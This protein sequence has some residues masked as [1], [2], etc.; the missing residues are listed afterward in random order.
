M[1]GHDKLAAAT[2]NILSPP[3][4]TFDPP[5]PYICHPPLDPAPIPPP[6][7]TTMDTRVRGHDNLGFR[8]DNDSLWEAAPAAECMHW[9][10]YTFASKDPHP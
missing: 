10:H 9:P 2:T 5:H 3:A 1:R 8:Y 7:P 4:L 6:P